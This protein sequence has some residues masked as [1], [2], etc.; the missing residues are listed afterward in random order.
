MK[1]R[2]RKKRRGEERKEGEKEE[3][4]GI[5]NKKGGGRKGLLTNFWRAH[6]VLPKLFP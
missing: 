2:E 1:R 6:S 3:S 5:D 4:R